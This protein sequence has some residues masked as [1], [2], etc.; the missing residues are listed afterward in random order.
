MTELK[1]SKPIDKEEFKNYVS[2]PLSDKIKVSKEIITEFMENIDMS[3]GEKVAITSSFGKDSVVVIDLVRS[4]YPEIPII[5]SDSGVEYPCFIE[6]SK[7]YDNVLYIKPEKTMEQ[8]VEENGYLLPLGREK[9]KT[10]RRCR[11]QIAQEKWYGG[12]MKKMRGDWGENSMYNYSKHIPVLLAPFKISEMCNDYL[13]GRPLDK[14]KKKN[15]FKYYFNGV[16]HDESQSRR[17]TLLR[18]GFNIMKEK[19][20]PIG[21]WT[22]SDVLEYVL[23]NDLPLGD[24]YGEIIYDEKKGKYVTTGFT[25]N[26]CYCC[27]AGAHIGKPNQYQLLYEYDKDLWE[28]TMDGLGFRKVCEYFDIPIK[29][30]DKNYK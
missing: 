24:T 9:T 30:G 8:V 7:Q 11:D 25:R 21:H 16:T 14:F 6:I 20:R 4:M 3:N 2:L 29:P 28:Y 19:S 17:R 15:G 13:K 1:Y 27:P 18:D 23:K 12:G 22:S 10:I 26:G 5:F